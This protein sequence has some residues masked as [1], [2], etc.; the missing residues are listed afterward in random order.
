MDVT[1]L[2]NLIRA[3]FPKRIVSASIALVLLPFC[4]ALAQVD[5]TCWAAVTQFRSLK[6]T[7]TPH[8]SAVA[9]IGMR[10]CVDSVDMARRGHAVDQADTA[11]IESFRNFFDI[12][13]YHDE[14]RLPAGQDEKGRLLGPQAFIYASPFL[15]GI[16]RAGQIYEQEMPG[17]LAAIVIVQRGPDE[18]LPQTYS[19]LHLQFGINCVWLHLPHPPNGRKD[20]VG[21]VTQLPFEAY[22]SQTDTKTS[23]RKA[24]MGNK[25]LP[26]NFSVG[27]ITTSPVQGPLAVVAVHLDHWTRFSD[28]PAVARF[29]TDRS[30]N[31]PVLAFKCLDAFCEVLPA[32]VQAAGVLNQQ[33]Y[34]AVRTPFELKRGNETRPVWNVPDSAPPGRPDIRVRVIKGWHDEQVLAE[35][36]DGAIW[37]PLGPLARIEPVPEAARYD[38]STF[39]DT[40]LPVAIITIARPFTDTTNKYY[41]WGLR[42]GRN[43]LW[44]RHANGKWAVE[45]RRG[46][47]HIP[48]IFVKRMRHF[49]AG[50]PATA[51]FR[52]TGI[53]DGVWVPCG[54]AC[55]R[56]DGGAGG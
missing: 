35:R 33:A 42:E 19:S 55:C 20:F 23:C 44:M 39:E 41:R 31:F 38:S 7:D 25:S 6:P 54:E 50:V 29:D 47:Q 28:Y 17:L 22:V 27:G 56:S 24:W 4:G 3:L 30:G 37:R 45:L 34:K 11:A 13:E 14:G 2:R 40:W 52:W 48:W 10:V 16:N 43:E 5:T 51:R 21:N 8:D 1:L 26:N 49:D 46:D 53:D 32:T 18:T 12:P 9:K 15:D 36:S